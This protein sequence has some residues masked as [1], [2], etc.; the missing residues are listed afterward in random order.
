MM[1]TLDSLERKSRI[2]GLLEALGDVAGKHVVDIGCGEGAVARALAER[3]AQVT[4]VDPFIEGTDRTEV[5]EGSY[6][7]ALGQADA[8]PLPDGSADIVLFV[9]SLHHVPGARMGGALKEAQRVLK[10][11]GTLCVAEPVA[12][13][14]A[15]YVMAPYHDETAVRANAIAALSAHA[16]PAFGSE[17]VAF[18]SEPR[19]FEGGFDAYAAEAIGNMR[20][21]GYSE[22]DATSDEVRRRFDEMAAIHGTTFDQ[23]VRMNLYR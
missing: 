11:G 10:P 3:G 22:E 1:G 23:P 8:L 9:Y 19:M 14:P 15:Q 4:G 6:Q 16:A 21:N 2:D 17:R 12:E 7:L 18:F 5:G 20:Y 13:G